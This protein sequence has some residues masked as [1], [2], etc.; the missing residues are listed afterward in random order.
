[1]Y[2]ISDETKEIFRFLREKFNDNILREIILASEGLKAARTCL[3]EADLNLF[4][5][6]AEQNKLQVVVSKEKYLHRKD[7]GKGGWS[8]SLE[9]V[10][11]PDYPDGLFNVYIATDLLIAENG[12]YFEDESN[13]REF[14]KLLGIPKCCVE[15]YI[16]SHPVAAL[17]QNDF[18]PLV[19]EN[20]DDKMPFIFWNNYVSQYFGRSLLSFFPCSFNCQKASIVAQTT[21]SVLQGCDLAW[22]EEFIKLQRTNILYTE[23][24]GLHLFPGQYQNGWLEYDSA[25]VLSTELTS[26]RKQI[27]EGNRLKIKNRREVEIYQNN[28]FISKI[29]GEDI[30]ICV[31][32]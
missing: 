1:M 16:R 10:V 6:V 7:I 3:T 15:T 27:N 25:S 5:P 9:K 2:I 28:V 19:L 8:N 11:K 14:G 18:V 26:I 22:A 24:L 31:F 30:G 21:F 23:Y 29:E 13:E 4:L 32:K 20:T 17:K 12:S